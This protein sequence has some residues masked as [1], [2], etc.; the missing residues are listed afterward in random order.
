MIQP[1]ALPIRVTRT[2]PLDYVIEFRGINLNSATVEMQVRQKPDNPGLPELSLTD[3]GAGVTGIRVISTDVVDGEQRSRVHVYIT[4]DDLGDIPA[5]ASVGDDLTWHYDILITPDGGVKGRYLAGPF[6]IGSAVTRSAT[7][8]AD[9]GT[10]VDAVAQVRDQ[11]V[12]VEVSG[13]ELIAGFVSGAS[14]Y[15]DMAAAY[16][17]Q[18]EEAAALIAEQADM[19][20]QGTLP[21]SGFYRAP[22]D[23]DPGT[24][25]AVRIG[26]NGTK[27]YPLIEQ[28]TSFKAGWSYGRLSLIDSATGTR[29][30]S[31]AMARL[32]DPLLA[33]TALST[34][35]VDYVAGNDAN[36]GSTGSPKKTVTGALAVSGDLNIGLRNRI[37]GTSGRVPSTTFSKTVRFFS[38][39]A[40]GAPV[41]IGDMRDNVTFTVTSL[42]DGVF[43]VDTT[44]YANI[45]TTPFL[46]CVDPVDAGGAPIAYRL[47]GTTY[48]NDA[49]RKAAVL[50]LAPGVGDGAW[51][52]GAGFGWIVKTADGLAPSFGPEGNHVYCE[53]VSGAPAWT[54]DE[55]EIVYVKGVRFVYNGKGAVLAALQLKP[56]GASFGSDLE[57]TCRF[58]GEDVGFYGSD[59][60]GLLSYDMERLAITN[61]RA[62]FNNSD[63]YSD[64]SYNA[65]DS[66]AGGE[67]MR[68]FLQDLRVDLAGATGMPGQPALT[69]SDN[70]FTP[71]D[72]HGWSTY[73]NCVGSNTYGSTM[74]IVG[75]AKAWMANCFMYDPT[76]PAGAGPI[77]ADPGAAGSPNAPYWADGTGTEL[78]LSG[79]GGYGPTE[80]LVATNGAVIF[81]DRWQGAWTGRV[82]NGGEIRDFDGNVLLS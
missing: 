68:S 50:A 56:V 40:A 72:R 65:V 5:A 73:V 25:M 15:S 53:P 82:V 29:W 7:A 47:D 80:T 70:A 33:G 39:R 22:P 69:G 48:A 74:A 61:G 66:D 52:A 31:V 57:H 71:H 19:V 28:T 75:G 9:G 78:W 36:D 8:S 37:L 34:V 16:A 67:W 79:C 41:W 2:T 24:D 81:V 17:A 77:D 30:R 21:R 20:E 6:V 49:A 10:G 64:H 18:A 76:N 60:Q 55:D 62:G 63:G 1:G 42:G 26:F 35:Y 13:S 27:A 44:A 11:L 46:M 59:A 23:W 14:D 43:K 38:D 51:V 4:E 45:V 3:V 32:L 54:I 12:V 58:A